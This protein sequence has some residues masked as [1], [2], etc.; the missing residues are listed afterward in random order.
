M[1]SSPS[2]G[3][4]VLLPVSQNNEGVVSLSVGPIVGDVALA[5]MSVRRLGL[6][7]HPSPES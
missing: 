2:E 3:G 5:F 7:V 1:P 6:S 4:E